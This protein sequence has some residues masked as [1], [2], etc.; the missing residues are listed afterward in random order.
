LGHLAKSLTFGIP[1]FVLYD[2]KD[3]RGNYAPLDR[4]AS[5]NAASRL[6]L[7]TMIRTP[8]IA[9]AVPIA[10]RPSKMIMGDQDSKSGRRQWRHQREPVAMQVFTDQYNS[11]LTW[12]C[13]CFVLTSTKHEGLPA[14]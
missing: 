14:A 7:N 11:L 8:V 1:A 9:T 3:A 2:T 6:N 13:R 4:I 5:I 12:A 10:M